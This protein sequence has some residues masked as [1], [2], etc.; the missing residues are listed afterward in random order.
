MSKNYTYHIDN[1]GVHK[2]WKACDSNIESKVG[3]HSV[4]HSVPHYKDRIAMSGQSLEALGEALK[5]RSKDTMYFD[6]Y[7]RALI[8]WLSDFFDKLRGKEGTKIAHELRDQLAMGG[9]EILGRTKR[10]SKLRD[11]LY[12]FEEWAKK[13]PGLEKK[14]VKYLIDNGKFGLNP[15]GVETLRG[16]FYRLRVVF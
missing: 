10:N 1:A 13:C 15:E 12:K 4:K 5:L 9:S 3:K 6:T 7:R 14:L 2:T 16:L 11:T 8:Q